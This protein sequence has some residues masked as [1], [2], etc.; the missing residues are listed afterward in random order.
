[1]RTL[2]NANENQR[3]RDSSKPVVPKSGGTGLQSPLTQ[4]NLIKII[5]QKL[6][7]I[8]DTPHWT[9][10]LAQV[11]LRLAKSVVLANFANQLC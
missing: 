9:F 4:A 11:H 8:Q 1:M 5:Q 2:P 6:S 7:N 3:T 10:D